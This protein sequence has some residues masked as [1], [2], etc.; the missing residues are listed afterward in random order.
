MLSVLLSVSVNAQESV[1][2]AGASFPYPVYASWSYYYQKSTGN[3]VSYSS[4]GSGGGV[5]SISD[6]TVD[7][8]A[9]DAPLKPDVQKEKKLLQFPAIIGGVVPVVNIK[10]LQRSLRKKPINLPSKVLVGIFLGEIT[11]WDDPALKAANPGVKLPGESIYVVHRSDKSG[12]T[13]IF[14]TYLSEISE[15]WKKQ[16]GF[17]GEVKWPVGTGGKGNEGVAEYVRKKNYSIGYVEFAYAKNNRLPYAHL[18]NKSG[19][20]VEPSFESFEE[21][22]SYAKWED[23]KGYYLWLVDAPGKNSW[24]IAGASFIL[25]ASEAVSAN[26][27]VTHFFNWV[28][29]NGDQTAKKLIYVPLPEALKTS[30]RSYWKKHGVF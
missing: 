3:Q 21:A 16:V 11:R 28:F 1:N 7:F 22:A 12:T 26:R 17:G 2:G 6:R 14:T 9:S 18:Q 20:F 8:G 27:K 19:N 25:M 23:D 4:I 24:P 15:K 5:R 29:E 13:A 30:I 10:E